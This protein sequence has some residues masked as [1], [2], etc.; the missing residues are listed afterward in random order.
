MDDKDKGYPILCFVLKPPDFLH[1]PLCLD[2]LNN[3]NQCQNGHNFCF[4]CI[5]QALA[6][7]NR[8]PVCMGPLELSK[9]SKNLF[10]NNLINDLEVK[11]H[12]RSVNAASQDVCHW[13]G[14]LHCRENHTRHCQHRLPIVCPFPVESCR[15]NCPRLFST[16]ELLQ[17]HLIECNDLKTNELARFRQRFPQGTLNT[18]AYTTREFPAS[19]G[20]RPAIYSGCF[21]NGV[22]HGCGV[23]EIFGGPEA[24]VYAG[25]FVDDL[26]NGQGFKKSKTHTYNGVWK[27]GLMHGHCFKFTRPDGVS[28]EGEFVANVLEGHAKVWS[29]KGEDKW[30]YEGEFH[31]DKRHGLGK[32]T[33]PNG[34]QT[35]VG[36]FVDDVV[37]G[38]GMIHYNDDDD[39]ILSG[40]FNDKIEC[41]G[42]GL[43]LH[44]TE[45]IYEGDFEHNLFHGVGVAHIPDGSLY[46][47]A[48]VKGKKHGRG[49]MTFADKSEY[50]GQFSQDEIHGEGVF[51]SAD[52]E[53]GV[54]KM[55]THG[56]IDH[57]KIVFDLMDI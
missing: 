15:E 21:L 14:P 24:A 1:C 30:C 7:F 55:Y 5:I 56:V 9:L 54:S 3:P 51:V 40:T 45:V 48:F 23:F 44:S 31:N 37:S 35:F 10:L 26:A 53:V 17:I 32:L 41:H 49:I 42:K 6:V 39:R 52:G 57:D 43:L 13:K 25:E 29:E 50:R 19:G 47:G 20:R 34:K 27:D 8:C 22:R 2:V 36:I 33:F 38:Q 16:R 28:G 46:R 12:E 11:C 18:R 4:V